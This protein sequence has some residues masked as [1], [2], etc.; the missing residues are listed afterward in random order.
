MAPNKERKGFDK[1]LKIAGTAIGQFLGKSQARFEKATRQAHKTTEKLVETIVTRSGQMTQQVTMGNI[2][3][4]TNYGE[5]PTEKMTTPRLRP[6][7]NKPIE[8]SIRILGEDIINYLIDNGKTT[9]A[10]M[11]MVMEKRRRNPAM[12]YGAIGWLAGD[13]R[14]HITRNGQNL[15]LR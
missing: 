9:T 3:K 5:E 2:P 8:E 1:H 4:T 15:S 7:K 14:I 13:N 11:M 10:E 6:I 12:I